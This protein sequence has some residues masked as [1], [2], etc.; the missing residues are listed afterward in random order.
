M[1][2]QVLEI[3]PLVVYFALAF[4]VLCFVTWIVS[5]MTRKKEGMRQ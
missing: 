2:S 5:R 1:S 3:P 4:V